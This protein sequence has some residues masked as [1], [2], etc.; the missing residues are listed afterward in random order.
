MSDH[1][2][3]L[4]QI[5]DADDPIRQQEV[6][7]FAAALVCAKEAIGTFDLLSTQLRDE[8]L[9]GYDMVVIGGSGRYSVTSEEPWLH[10]ALRSLQFLL[11]TGKPTFASCWG[12]QALSRAAGGKVTHDLEHAELGTH[13][14]FLT[15]E[16]R[17]DLIFSQ[18]PESFRT[19]MGHEDRVT[20]LPP[21]AVL[22]ASNDRVAQQAFRFEGQPVYCSQFHPELTLP[23]L[24]TR[25][26][27]YPEYCERI[28]KIPF[29]VFR[30]QCEP[31]PESETILKRFAD[32]FLR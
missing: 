19:Y 24:M 26:E 22:L 9:E 2:Y 7:C 11:E 18:L 10:Q 4:I 21:G 28:A 5:R 25:I 13:R 8:H 23:T 32:H 14:V 16:G 29:E 3:L 27:A 30:Q 20:E 1:R 12:F 17:S 15:E 6:D 31:A